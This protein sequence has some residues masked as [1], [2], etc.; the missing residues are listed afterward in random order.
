VPQTAQ[1]PFMACLPFFMVTSFGFFISVFFLHL[2]QYASAIFR[3]FHRKIKKFL[4]PLHAPRRYSTQRDSPYNL[5][6]VF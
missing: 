1:V 4:H 2:T 6:H 3:S 5:I